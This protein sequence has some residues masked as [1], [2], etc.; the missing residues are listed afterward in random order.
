MMNCLIK[1]DNKVKNLKTSACNLI[2]KVVLVDQTFLLLFAS[3]VFD[4][5]QN[6]I[7][8]R[9]CVQYLR[10]AKLQCAVDTK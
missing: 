2:T 6:L 4:L 1:H 10:T 9:S 3:K 8:V 7:E 5:Q